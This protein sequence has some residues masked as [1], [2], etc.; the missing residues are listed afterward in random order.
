MK[1]YNGQPATVTIADP[2]VEVVRPMVAVTPTGFVPA[3]MA[4]T[5]GQYTRH[6]AEHVDLLGLSAVSMYK[7]LPCPSTSTSPS[8]V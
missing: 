3:F 4:A 5:G 6:C 2:A 8:E 7:V 1:L